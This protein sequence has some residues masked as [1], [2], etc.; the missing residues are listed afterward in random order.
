MKKLAA[1]DIKYNND[2]NNIMLKLE[3]NFQSINVKRWISS[4]EIRINELFAE[5][6]VY[7]YNL[8]SNSYTGIVLECLSNIKRGNNYKNNS[9]ND[10]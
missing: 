4:I 9:S 8:N 2:C 10:K 7:S 3:K 6:E 1:F 5:Y